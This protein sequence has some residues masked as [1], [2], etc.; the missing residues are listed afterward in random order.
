MDHLIQVFVTTFNRP[1]LLLALLRDLAEQRCC[2]LRRSKWDVRLSVY[3]DCST[4]DYTSVERFVAFHGWV[5]FRRNPYNQGKR[6]YWSTFN[7]IFAEMRASGAGYFVILQDDVELCRDFFRVALDYWRGILD[8]NKIAL[9][10]LCDN[11]SGKHNWTGMHTARVRFPNADVILSGW[12]DGMWLGTRKTL[13]VLEH[14]MD[15]ISP[16]RW[17]HDP[18]LSSGVGR[19][20]TMRLTQAGFNI[21]TVSKSLVRLLP[22]DSLMHPTGRKRDPIYEVRFHG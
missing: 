12:L 10:I 11:R 13:G 4:A 9:N 7:D 5:S 14:R 17:R 15:P 21:Y 18:L 6:E 22:C 3:D 19:Q 8:E 1:A 2:L 20:I 16:L